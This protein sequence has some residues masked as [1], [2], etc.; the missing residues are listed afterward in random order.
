MGRNAKLKAER[1]RKR[2]AVARDQEQRIGFVIAPC[3]YKH[4]PNGRPPGDLLLWRADGEGHYASCEGCSE[5][6]MRS[7]KLAGIDAQV[8]TVAA[9]EH[10]RQSGKLEVPP[11]SDSP[12]E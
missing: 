9:L 1:R 8:V 3:S 2:T 12:V 4:C 10:L 11:E 7:L 5:D 6:M